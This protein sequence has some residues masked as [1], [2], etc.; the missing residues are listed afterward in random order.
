[1]D[2]A[3]NASIAGQAVVLP[4]RVTV[5]CVRLVLGSEVVHD[6]R[7]LIDVDVAQQQAVVGRRCFG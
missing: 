6:A 7:R 2:H 1:M 5:T 3:F 4:G